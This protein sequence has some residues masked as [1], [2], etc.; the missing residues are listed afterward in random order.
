MI[1]VSINEKQYNVCSDWKDVT[2]LHIEK[3]Y[4]LKEK[5]SESLKKFFYSA[6]EF[7]FSKEQEVELIKF[8]KEWIEIF[9]NIPKNILNKTVLV[10]EE[11]DNITSL[12]KLCQKFMYKPQQNEIVINECIEFKGVKYY[13]PESVTSA[14]GIKK[15]FAKGTYEEYMESS[16]LF[17]VF[18]EKGDLSKLSRL[19]AILFRP[20]IKVG[21][22][23]NRKEVIEEF[24]EEKVNQRAELFKQLPMNDVWAAYFFFILS[25]WKLLS[26]LQISL[27]EANSLSKLEALANEL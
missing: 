11:G 6:D 26:G 4:A 14:K 1:I 17:D 8:E 7:S 10:N 22:F 18:N 20:K 2:I 12:F 16:A 25:N 9:S 21:Y 3:G 15:L 24:D 13:L 19:T 5:L 23:W 27:K